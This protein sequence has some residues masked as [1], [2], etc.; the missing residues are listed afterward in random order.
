MRTQLLGRTLKPLR[1]S[2]QRCGV[3][4]KLALRSSYGAAPDPRHMQSE[5][6]GIIDDGLPVRFAKRV[7]ALNAKLNPLFVRVTASLGQ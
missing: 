6:D 2:A 7:H 3:R 1:A 4:G 5:L